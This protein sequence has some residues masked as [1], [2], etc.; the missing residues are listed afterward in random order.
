LTPEEIDIINRIKNGDKKAFEQLV[1]IHE[2]SVLNICYRFL[3]NREDAEDIAQ[4]IFIEIF[5]SIK[6]FR[7]EAK[8]STW[9]YRISVT[10]CLDEIKKRNRLKR[11]SSV[12]KIFN[13]DDFMGKLSG[14][15]SA[16]K[17]IEQEEDLQK[18]YKALN[19]LPENQRIALTLS[20]IDS[21]SN[22]DAAEIMKTS[23]TS[24][25]SLIYR[26]KQ[27]LKKILKK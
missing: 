11:I 14:Y 16:D 6:N 21:L 26:A 1:D 22:K 10:K 4:D 25:D 5:Y 12:G 13:L 3:L 23:L 27:N 24:I 8:L 2:K 9:I 20:K 19:K 7:A 15:E 18:I 17:K